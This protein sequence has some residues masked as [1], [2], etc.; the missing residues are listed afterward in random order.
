[1]LVP[2]KAHGILLPSPAPLEPLCQESTHV[3]AS[4]YILISPWQPPSKAKIAPSLW[5]KTLRLR[6]VKQ[7]AQGHT[8]SKGSEPRSVQL[9]SQCA[10]STK[11]TAAGKVTGV[12]PQE[13]NMIKS[14]RSFNQQEEKS[15]GAQ[16]E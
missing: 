16:E 11:P 3:G 15:S 12:L 4:V 6:S 8:A 9:Q 5:M 2:N 14:G 1:M 13:Q 10:R 7:L